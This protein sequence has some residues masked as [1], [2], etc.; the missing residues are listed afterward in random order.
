MNWK[1]LSNFGNSA[2]TDFLY[3]FAIK[4]ILSEMNIDWI[5]VIVSRELYYFK[6]N[7]N[8]IF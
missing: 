5:V 7:Q 8:Y 1:R 4:I 6:A 3:S 2:Q